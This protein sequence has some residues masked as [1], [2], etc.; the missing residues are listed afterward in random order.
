MVQQRPVALVT[1]GA[2][3]V[4]R[5]IVTRLAHEGYDVA[6]IYHTSITNATDLVNELSSQVRVVAIR[7][8]FTQPEKARDAI[9]SEFLQH[10][11]RLDVL[12]NSASI[13]KEGCEL[14][15][16]RQCNAVH[17]ETPLLLIR[18]FEAKLRAAR[19]HIINMCDLLADRPWP[20]FAAYCASKA[21]LVNL[22]KSLALDLAPDVTVNGIAPGVVAWAE[23]MTEADREK[24]LRRVPLSRAGTPEDVAE[25]VLF[26]A[27]NAD[28]VTGQILNLDGGRSIT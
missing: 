15:L 7:A 5:A 3:R 27:Q 9:Q 23:G 8:D 19:G 2:K 22:T 17:I 20:K 24:Y 25:I 18:A 13:Y 1:G 10:F 14:E 26:F 6:F 28:Y 21:A 12:V 11:H 4:G 16:F